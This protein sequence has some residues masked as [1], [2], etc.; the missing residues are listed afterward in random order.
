MHHR[1]QIYTGL[2]TLGAVTDLYSDEMGVELLPSVA[3]PT[4]NP[5]GETQ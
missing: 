1:G 3:V 2:F 5:A 4:R